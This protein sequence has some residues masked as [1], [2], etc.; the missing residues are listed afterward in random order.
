MGQGMNKVRNRNYEVISRG[1]KVVAVY[2]PLVEVRD[3]LV[4]EGN[5]HYALPGGGRQQL[6]VLMRFYQRQGLFLEPV[7]RS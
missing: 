5:V 6:S 4:A 1:G 7:E 3:P 2:A